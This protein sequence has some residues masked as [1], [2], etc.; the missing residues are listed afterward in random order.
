MNSSNSNCHFR[1][2]NLS[3]SQCRSTSP[4][5][6]ARRPFRDAAGRRTEGGAPGSGAHVLA[7]IQKLTVGI[8]GWIFTDKKALCIVF[9]KK[10]SNGL[11]CIAA[12]T[13]IT[14]NYNIIKCYYLTVNLNFSIFIS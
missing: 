10:N 8:G 4:I 12:I 5:P 13:P 1:V 14:R 3:S 11:I 9:L 6:R 7:H 2:L